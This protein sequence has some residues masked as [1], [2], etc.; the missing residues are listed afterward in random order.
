MGLADIELRSQ[1]AARG[2]KYVGTRGPVG[3]PV[4][5][6]GEAPG[7]EEDQSGFPFVGQSGKEIDRE[8][9]EAGFGVGDYWFT[10]PYKTR[11]PNNDF[12]KLETLG[13]PLKTFEDQFFEELETHK[14]RLII[15]TGATPLRLLCPHTA[16]KRDDESKVGKWRGSLLTSLRLGWEHYIIPCY[17]PAF[18]LRDWSERDTNVF[19]LK[20]VFEEFDYW[21]KNGK[22]QPL[23]QRELIVEPTFDTSFAFLTDL[24]NSP[25]P[26]SVDIELLRRKIPYTI[27]LANSAQ[28]A[29][30]I[31]VW[32]Y[33]NDHTIS[34]WRLLRHVFEA[35]EIIGQNFT[36]FDAHWLNSL[37]FV[38]DCNRVDDTRIRHNILWPELSHKLEFMVM[39][40]TREPY[41]KDEGRGWSPREGKAK[42]MRYNAKDAACTFEVYERQEEEF[43][44]R[45]ELQ[46]FY[47][48]HEKPLASNMFNIERRGVSV[49]KRKLK[50]LKLYIQQELAKSCVKIAKQVG[51]PVAP[52]KKTAEI[53]GPNTINLGAPGQVLEM[54]KGLGLKVPRKRGTGKESTDEETLHLMYA[55]S[56]HPVLQ[57]MLFLR[58]LNKIGG[59]NVNA[60]LKDGCLF[61]VYIVGGTVGGRRASHGSPLGYGSNH[62]NIPKHSKLGKKYRDCLVSRPNKIFVMCDQVSAEDW[63]I[64]GIITDQTGDTHAL[65][66]LRDRSIDRHQKLA[67]FIFAVPLDQCNR[68]A[69]TPYR[70]IGKRTRYAG[71]YGMGA[72]KFAAVLAKEGYS[73][74]KD[75]CSYILQKFHEYEPAIKMVFQ[76]YVEK[77]VTNKRLLRDLFGRERQ[78]FGLHPYRDNSKIFREAFSYIPQS[79]IGDNTGASINWLE[80]TAPGL[81]VMET[82]DSVVLEVDDCEQSVIN[83]VS[84]LERS[85]D[86]VLRFPRGLELKIPIA[87]EIGYSLQDTIR[88]DNLSETGLMSTLNTYKQQRSPL[89]TI[90]SGV[91]QPLSQQA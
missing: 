64:Q 71:S 57:E 7:A 56:G 60:K 48:E 9:A 18:I 61:C 50:G 36:S 59:T 8:L 23:P 73:V 6:V 91:L 38:S 52:D 66:E 53:L 81:V 65:D 35:K 17:H 42:L 62:Q 45:P 20:K 21:R 43:A 14:P 16:S 75:H 19:V 33:D 31:G 13:V 44:E 40:Y 30:S 74:P 27:G 26:V 39:Q 22:L 68:D 37:G 12:D 63:L 41:Y 29:I 86:R 90:I 89:K 67:S 32:D 11:P 87:H 83:A 2:L 80:K 46:T 1:L 10:N 55:E 25:Q 85:F 69:N 4:C 51:K 82:H 47:R 79:T 34:L 5:I 77:E 88:C 3:A 15:A 72:D 24:L 28:R 84:L 76:A 58:E 54:F 78:F 49:D 70:Y